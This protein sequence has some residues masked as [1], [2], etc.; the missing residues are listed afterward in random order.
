MRS[1]LPDAARSEG[2]AALTAVELA[3]PA[4]D[5][6]FITYD[7]GVVR[8]QVAAFRDAF[9]DRVAVRYAVKCNPDPLVLAAVA[10]SGGGFEIASLAEL[11]L[12]L[13]AGARPADVLY[14]NPVKAPGHVAGA[15]ARGVVRFAVDAP[16]ELEKVARHAPG[17]GVYV[18]LAVDDTSSRFPLSAKFGTTREEARR[19]L[20]AAPGLGLVPAGLTFHV[21]SQCTDPD[22]WA[23]AV[24][25]CAP[26]MAELQEGGVRL[27]MLDVGGGFPARYAPSEVLPDLRDVGA[28]V[29]EALESLPYVPEELYCEPGRALV[30]ES[31]VLGATVIGRAERSG[32]VWVYTDVGAYNGLMEAAQT[33]G[34]LAFP[35]TTSRT[36]LA[37]GPTVHCTVTGPSC[38]SSDTLLRDAVLPAGLEV[39]D[40]VYLGSAGAYSVCYASTF[41]GFPLPRARYV[42]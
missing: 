11:D 5:T 30:A 29:L 31:A 13:A 21:G 6:P 2:T 22:A 19:L 40:R 32:R 9:R 42:G 15:A 16:E 27:R 36:D 10:S 3:G 28:R 24:R 34:T 1:L 25:L 14:S 38:D 4:D 37:G 8:R 33:S 17:A 35:V 7:L 20:L 26:L 39:G 18:R 12:A 41:N 23:H